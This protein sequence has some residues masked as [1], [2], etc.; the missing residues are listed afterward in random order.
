M[1]SF[2]ASSDAV[3]H[4][5]APSPGGADLVRH[6]TTTS[7]ARALVQLLLVVVG[8]GV[9]DLLDLRGAL[10]DL[11][12]VAGAWVMVVSSLMRTFL[13]LPMRELRV[14]NSSLTA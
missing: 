14:L 10:A 4:P 8:G 6:A 7:L 9:L 5:S 2:R 1:P 3:L 13:A 12:L 11:L